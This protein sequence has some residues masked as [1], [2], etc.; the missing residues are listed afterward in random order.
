MALV[1]EILAQRYNAL[2]HKLLAIRG[3]EPAPQLSPDIQAVIVLEEDRFEN[4]ILQETSAWVGF[5]SI[6]ASVGNFTAV[7]VVM[8]ANTGKF[9]VVQ[10][11]LVMASASAVQYTIRFGSNTTQDTTTTTTQ[12]EFGRQVQAP[13]TQIFTTTAA[14]QP[15]TATLMNVTV[16]AN[17]SLV[18]PINFT[19]GPAISFSNSVVVVPSV[20]NLAANVSFWGYERAAEFSERT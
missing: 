1:N 11:V 17:T 15:G 5:G 2:L 10:A 12:R 4:L 18:I 8:P 7:G 14:A 3:A 6:G 19:L 16:P 13:V 9:S 20:V